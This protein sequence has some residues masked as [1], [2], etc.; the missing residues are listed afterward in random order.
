MSKQDQSVLKL[1]AT[2]T[3][4]RGDDEVDTILEWAALLPRDAG[5][6]PFKE[7]LQKH[8][9]RAM[10]Q[11]VVH[12]TPKIPLAGNLW[13]ETTQKHPLI[14]ARTPD[15][16]HVAPIPPKNSGHQPVE[17]QEKA[18]KPKVEDR[19]G[20]KIAESMPK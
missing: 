9:V 7:T 18:E 20:A 11:Y 10:Y 4:G 14:A 3:G 16:T 15:K 8:L 6:E 13:V 17:T 1:V 2:L 12:G 5:G 19:L